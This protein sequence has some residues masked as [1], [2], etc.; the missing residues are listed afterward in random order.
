[1]KV[2]GGSY[3]H[4][5]VLT[6]E[7]DGSDKVVVKTCEEYESALKNGYY[8]QS[9]Y[10]IKMESWFIHQCGLLNALSNAILPTKSYMSDPRVSI[11]DLSR[12]PYKM[13]PEL[14]GD[15]RE[16]NLSYQ[17]KINNGEMVVKKIASNFLNIECQYMGQVLIEIFRMDLN[18]D[19][20]EDVFLYEYMY[21]T[22]GTF[23]AANVIVL[24]ILNDGDMF[25][26]ITKQC[27]I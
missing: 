9:Q 2:G 20:I 14:T 11:L 3:Y 27:N 1:M 8:A 18:G 19:G 7:N 15:N 17:D 24:S 22:E 25:T 4:E 26:D 16:S 21:A 12:L 10:D 13:F 5:L 6:N 23:G